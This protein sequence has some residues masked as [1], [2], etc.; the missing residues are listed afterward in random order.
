MRKKL[1]LA[2]AVAAA[3]EGTVA[4]RAAAPK[5]AARIRLRDIM[6]NLQRKGDPRAIWARCDNHATAQPHTSGISRNTQTR[7]RHARK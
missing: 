3:A 1:V 6:V 4:I 7:Y 2:G 5:T